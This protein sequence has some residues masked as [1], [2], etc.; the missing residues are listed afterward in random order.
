M[1]RTLPETQATPKGKA[2]PKVLITDNINPSAVDLLGNDVEVVYEKSLSARELA[3]KIPEMD[4]LMVRSASQVTKDIIHAGR[5]LKIIGR[6]G[7]GT[8]NIDLA[9]ATQQGIIVV[10]SPE[11]NTVA[12]S[13]HTV[14]M[15]LSLARH[16]PE[17]DASMKAGE[18]NRGALTG[19][20]VFGKTLGVIGLGKIGSRVAKA[21]LAMGMRVNVFDPFLSPARAEE[22]GVNPVD[23]DA[24]WE[25]SDFITL[26]APKTRETANLLNRDT[27]AKCRPGVRIV[28]CARGGIVNEADLAAALESGHVGGAALDVFEN[29]PLNPDSPLLKLGGKV[30]LTP[31][32]GASTKEAQVNVAVDVAKQIRDFFKDG[33]ARNAVNLP[34]LRKEILDPVKHYMPMS[35]V[36][37]SLIRQFAKG[38]A[39]S[40]EITAKGTVAR[41]DISPLT[42]AVLKGMLSLNREG[43]NYVNARLI[44]EELGIEVKESLVTSVESFQ[45]LLQITLVTDQ[46]TYRV[47]GTLI[48]GDNFRIVD[49]DGYAVT[50]EP[51]EH[52]LFTPHEDK[53]GMV[54]LVAS[55]LGNEKTNISAL[56]VA[57]RIGSKAPGGESIM[58]FNLDTPVSD[59]TL[60]AI[61]AQSGIIEALYIHL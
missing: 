47:A 1:S 9:E 6:A 59:S 17:A 3:E 13:E 10:N 42:L 5:R 14:G 37:G 57:R 28:N 54:G 46:R 38:A 44:A 23:L 29:E 45:N 26:H 60:A 32:L 53:P 19:V 7:V 4:A 20:E 18:W 8:D 56:Q 39:Q 52:I 35:E 12:A 15:L 11:G 61:R 49:V 21:C 27:L 30:I 48:H 33:Y 24:I 2:K 43:V 55:I 51:T 41:E 22:L 50:L 40:V 36:L 31:H 25:E 58:I 34:T 16:I